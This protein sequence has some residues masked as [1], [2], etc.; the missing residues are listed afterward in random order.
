MKR[1]SG[2][3]R[4]GQSLSWRT[5][6]T[7]APTT[8]WGGRTGRSRI[9][10]NEEAGPVLRRLCR[11]DLSGAIR[12]AGR[13]AAARC[14]S[15]SGGGNR[16][17]AS[18]AGLAET[19]GAVSGWRGAGSG[20]GLAVSAAGQRT[21]GSAGWQPPDA[22]HDAGGVS[23]GNILRHK[24]H[25]TGGGAAGKAG[26]LRRFHSFAA[27]ARPADHGRCVPAKRL[28]HPGR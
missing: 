14:F 8:C 3:Y 23:C 28:T 27:D 24:S 13:L 1:E 19:D 21:D 26:L 6:T 7:S 5:T 10:Q 4:H 25:R 22:D 20:M 2:K 17:A 9:L 12:P 18:A 16:R 11:R 15:V